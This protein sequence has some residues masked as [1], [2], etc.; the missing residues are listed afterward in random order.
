MSGCNKSIF[1]GCESD[2]KRGFC[3]GCDE[4]RYGKFL[5]QIKKFEGVPKQYE[6]KI[7]EGCDYNLNLIRPFIIPVIQH[8][9]HEG[10]IW[11]RIP[12]TIFVNF[13]EALNSF[14][15]YNFPY[16]DAEDEYTVILGATDTGYGSEESIDTLLEKLSLINSIL[17]IA[18]KI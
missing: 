17:C 1:S 2:A 14:R 7:C 18:E 6:E 13:K 4:D 11:W 9:S 3:F 12:K 8:D 10:R 5:K 16:Q 15:E